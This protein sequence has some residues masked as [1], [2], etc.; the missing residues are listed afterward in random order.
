MQRSP[1][2]N[3]MAQPTI[4]NSLAFEIEVLYDMLDALYELP[5]DTL[6]TGD[7]GTLFVDDYGTPHIL[8]TFLTYVNELIGK[9]TFEECENQFW[10]IQTFIHTHIRT[11]SRAL[12]Q[13][14]T[15]ESHAQ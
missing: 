4:E 12:D 5:V 7:W 3:A 8:E 9:T 2:W 10:Y 6:G 11:I 1:D 15:K 14:Q 13:V